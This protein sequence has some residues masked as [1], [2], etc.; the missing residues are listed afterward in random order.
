MGFIK[1][2]PATVFLLFSNT[3]VFIACYYQAKTFLNPGW[4]THLIQNGCGV[5]PPYPWQEWY[6]IFTHM[7]LHGHIMHLAFQ[8]VCI[9]F[10]WLC[11]GAGNRDKK[12]SWVYVLAGIAASLSSLYWNPVHDWC[13][14]FGGNFWALWIFCVLNLFQTHQQ[15]VSVTPFLSTLVCSWYH[16]LFCQST[17]SW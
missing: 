12:I 8:H 14:G 11:A 6:R 3:F 5:Q 13:R 1:R 9:I 17:P 2:F 10:C 4:T 15:V 16:L 7:F